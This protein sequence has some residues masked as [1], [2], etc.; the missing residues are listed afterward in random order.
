MHIPTIDTSTSGTRSFLH[1]H[2]CF[3]GSRDRVMIILM[4]TMAL[5]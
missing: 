2:F 3:H 4:M 1:E 5:S